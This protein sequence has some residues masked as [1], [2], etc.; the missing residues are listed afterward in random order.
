MSQFNA[1]KD[2]R[3]GKMIYNKN[4]MYIGK[5]LELYGEYSEAEIDI[6]RQVIHQGDTVLEI[7]AN[8]SITNVYCYQKA[9]GRLK[10]L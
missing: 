1:L 2:C 4:D 7:G 8:L 9:V 3:Y 10:S 5:S 6:F